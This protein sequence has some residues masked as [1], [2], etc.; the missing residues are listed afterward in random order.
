MHSTVQMMT[1]W[2]YTLCVTLTVLIDVSEE[3]ATIFREE[4]K[5][6]K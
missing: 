4:V 1:L 5:M 3:T 6:E 2:I